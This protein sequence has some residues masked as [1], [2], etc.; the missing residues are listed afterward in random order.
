MKPQLVTSGA[1][2]AATRA[3][4]RLWLCLGGV[5]V[6]TNPPEAA[7]GQEGTGHCPGML[8]GL[9]DTG[10]EEETHQCGGGRGLCAEC[11]AL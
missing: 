5:Q 2:C 4:L 9:A 3:G 1:V 8:L 7:V 6:Q 11:P 10:W